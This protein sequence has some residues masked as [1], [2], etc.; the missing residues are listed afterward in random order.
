MA[1]FHS[2]S[3]FDFL[4]NHSMSQ[5]D[6]ASVPKKAMKQYTV[7]QKRWVVQRRLELQAKFDYKL[8]K[9][10][11]QWDYYKAMFPDYAREKASLRD[12]VWDKEHT[13]TI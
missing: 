11:Q 10:D 8:H 13:F 7:E 9:N 6:S 1:A 5:A 4:P 2:P 3:T 12:T